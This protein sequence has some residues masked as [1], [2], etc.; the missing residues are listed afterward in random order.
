MVK[1]CEMSM[2]FC[3]NRDCLQ[4]SKLAVGQLASWPV[5]RLAG[6]PVGQLAGWP[7]ASW[8]VGQLAGWPV[9]QLAL[10][11]LLSSFKEKS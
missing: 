5:G 1:L 9:V 3:K 6:W 11:S 4:V 10:L 8:P 2:L 7:V